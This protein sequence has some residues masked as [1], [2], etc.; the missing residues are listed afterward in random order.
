MAR[1]RR[2]RPVVASNG[3]RRRSSAGLRSKKLNGR[4]SN[5][6]FFIDITGFEQAKRE[7]ILAYHSQFVVNVKN[8]AVV[9]WVDAAGKYFG[10]RI[11]TA[12]AE[13]FFA[14]EPIGL[15]GL[16]GLVGVDEPETK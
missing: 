9:D 3:A 11:G 2:Q 15:G 10:S 12:A 7:A 13:P 1:P 4:N 6:V 14:R 5:L 16:A 8:R